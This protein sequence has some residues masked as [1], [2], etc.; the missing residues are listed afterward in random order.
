MKT[1]EEIE[2]ELSDI[3]SEIIELKSCMST[4]DNEGQ[5]LYDVRLLT[6]LLSQQSALKWVLGQS[7]YSPERVWY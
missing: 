4:D 6:A 2:N 5:Q 7:L 1:R 3:E